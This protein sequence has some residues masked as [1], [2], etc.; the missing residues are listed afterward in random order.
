LRSRWDYSH[1]TLI[2]F[3]YCACIKGQDFSMR[4]CL[5]KSPVHN[6]LGGIWLSPVSIIS[7]NSTFLGW[8]DFFLPKDH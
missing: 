5:G 3:P 1:S 2:Y 6:D 4:A 7:T 8:I